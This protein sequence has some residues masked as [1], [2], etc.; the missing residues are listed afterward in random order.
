MP[1]PILLP[2][3][4]T[5][6]SDQI[7]MVDFGGQL[8]PFMG[9]PVQTI[10][11]LGTRFALDITVPQ[12]RTEPFGRIFSSRLM[13]A[14]IFGALIEFRQDGL[15]VNVPGG[16]VLVDGAG[17]TGFVLHQRGFR[18][19][20]AVREGQFFSLLSGGQRYLHRAATSI[21]VGGDG[22]LVLPIFPMLRVSPADGDVCEWGK[23]MMQGSLSG[24]E[25]LWKRPPADISD[26]GTITITEDE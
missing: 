25:A 7:H 11:R 24:N 14:K 5:V 26:F 6:S 16:P 8:K 19:G 12:M 18:P 3:K 10:M 15:K 1:D 4:G 9:G 21:V 20:Y 2:N 13:Q 22:K 17:Q 23:P